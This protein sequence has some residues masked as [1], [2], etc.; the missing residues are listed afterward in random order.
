MNPVAWV[1]T[2]T[3]SRGRRRYYVRHSR[4]GCQTAWSILGATMFPLPV[5]LTSVSAF[6]R[7]FDRL[8][9]EGREPSISRIFQES[10]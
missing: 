10:P 3:A 2:V 1:I 5:T 6:N 8:E 4:G 7:A 9:A